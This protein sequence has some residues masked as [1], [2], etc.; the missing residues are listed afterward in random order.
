MPMLRS[1]PPGI[2]ADQICEEAGEDRQNIHFAFVNLD[3][4]GCHWRG[5]CKVLVR[6]D[7]PDLGAMA[8]LIDQPTRCRHADL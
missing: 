3:D 1:G 7:E 5:V 2:E 8:H 4:T 6:A